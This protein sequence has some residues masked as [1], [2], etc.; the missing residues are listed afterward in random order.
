MR[1]LIPVQLSK[2]AQLVGGRILMCRYL[3][4]PTTQAVRITC[5]DTLAILDDADL[6]KRVVAFSVT[7]DFISKAT[8][9]CLA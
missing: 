9:F 3:F 6:T 1:F 7:L 2:P 5:R 8:R 4:V